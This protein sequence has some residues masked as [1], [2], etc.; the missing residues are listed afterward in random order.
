M[1]EIAFTQ[2]LVKHNQSSIIIAAAGKGSRL[3]SNKPKILY[4]LAGKTILEWIYGY[5]S[6]ICEEI[7]LVLS[8]EGKKKVVPFIDE[9][10][11]KNIK[12]AIQGNPVGM[13]DAIKIG[14]KKNTKDNIFIV[15]GDQPC[16][17]K[18][19]L[20]FMS[21]S[22]DDIKECQMI[23]PALKTSNPYVHY[24]TDT[25]GLLT[26]VLEKRENDI[27]PNFGL[28][29]CGL[30]I[31]KKNALENIFTKIELLEPGR[32]TKEKSFIRLLPTLEKNDESIRYF[33]TSSKLECLSI[34]TQE[35]AKIV[36]NY[37]QSNN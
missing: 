33:F 1:R 20:E 37:L 25:S 9:K 31:I 10:G 3:K 16:Y 21:S 23:F 34:N 7:I 24:E 27:M 8:P 6:E 14:L 26:G 30:F 35:E 29:D 28:S 5:C 18:N 36:E 12:V 2:K 19:T 32:I 4:S 15:W 22:L 11:Y 17:T 13:A